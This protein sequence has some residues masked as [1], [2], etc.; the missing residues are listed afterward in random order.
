[1][2][3]FKRTL[4]LACAPSNAHCSNPRPHLVKQLLQLRLPDAHA[5]QPPRQLRQVGARRG[6]K[7][8]GAGVRQVLCSGQQEAIAERVLCL[9]GGVEQ[10]RDWPVQGGRLRQRARRVI[11]AER[12]GRVGVAQADGQA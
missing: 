10:V 2:R 11:K 12:A 9:G 1:M 7:A 4:Q 3:P 5:R 6:R 8:S